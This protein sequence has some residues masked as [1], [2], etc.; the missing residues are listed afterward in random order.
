MTSRD[1]SRT[2]HSEPVY[3]GRILR[4][5]LDRVELPNGNVTDLEVINGVCIGQEVM[6]VPQ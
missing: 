5:R 2:L 1:D 4:V 6:L 3:E